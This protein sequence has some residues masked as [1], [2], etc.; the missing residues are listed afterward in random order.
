MDGRTCSVG[1]AWRTALGIRA[2]ADATGDATLVE[3]QFK[4][5][6]ADDCHRALA[7]RSGL[8]NLQARFS[9]SK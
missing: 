2:I 6:K 9:A 7:L 1:A 8:N 5:A 4:V 3:K